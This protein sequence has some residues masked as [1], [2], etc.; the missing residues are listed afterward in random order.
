M[1]KSSVHRHRQAIER[2]NQYPE[3]PLWELQRQLVEGID[4]AAAIEQAQAACNATDA[5]VRECLKLENI[6][7]SQFVSKGGRHGTVL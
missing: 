4:E 6:R 2:R 5:S 7:S 3:S 1:T